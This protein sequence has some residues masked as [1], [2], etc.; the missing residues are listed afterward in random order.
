MNGLKLLIQR[1][2]ELDQ[3]TRLHWGIGCALVLVLTLLYSLATDQVKRLQKQRTIKEAAV[4]EL[5]VLQQRYREATT[6]AQKIANRLAAVKPDDSPARVIEETGIKGKGTQI[7]PLKSEERGGFTED[8]AEVKIDALT[9]NEMV[10]LLYRLEQGPRPV[11]VRRAFFK[12]RFDD[13]S[14]LDLSLTIALLKSA[15][16][17]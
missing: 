8:S 10:N 9:P 3:R 2:N 7:K 15:S 17:Q 4:S 14:R 13:P 16:R 1:F 5:L 12:T 6:T 11:I